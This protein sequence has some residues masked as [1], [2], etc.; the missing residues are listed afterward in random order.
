MK[1]NIFSFI[2]FLITSCTALH[3]VEPVAPLRFRTLG[4]GVDLK[5]LFYVDGQK[6]KPFVVDSDRRSVYYDYSIPGAPISFVK[7]VKTPDGKELREPV[8]QVEVDVLLRRVLLV[9]TKEPK[10]G[11]YKILAIKDDISSVPP[12]GYQVLNFLPVSAGLLVGTE[13]QIIPAG[14]ARALPNTDIYTFKL[15]GVAANT[16]IPV[17]SNI[18]SVDKETRNLVLIVMNSQGTGVDVKFLGESV[19]AVLPDD[20]APAPPRS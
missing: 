12:G 3:A 19:R 1:S 17:F 10:G 20:P 6:L 8:A 14:E 5:E 9:F 18:F 15:F 2:F 4:V 11:A 7:V 13:K 16:A